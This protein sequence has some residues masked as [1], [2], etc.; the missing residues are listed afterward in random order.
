MQISPA[1]EMRGNGSEPRKV[2][3]TAPTIPTAVA[4]P[5]LSDALTNITSAGT[6]SLHVETW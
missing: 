3:L 5:M 6:R 4:V 1:P 2:E